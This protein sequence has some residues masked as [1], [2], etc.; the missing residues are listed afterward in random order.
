[1][2]CVLQVNRR[3]LAIVRIY[4]AISV[5]LEKRVRRERSYL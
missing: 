2:V 3:I 5:F 4:F 1:V